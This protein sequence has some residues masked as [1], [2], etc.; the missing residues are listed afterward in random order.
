MPQVSSRN[1]QVH[2]PLRVPR[3]A[4][5][6]RLIFPPLPPC[7]GKAAPA[8][9]PGQILPTPP[10]PP[11]AS[12]RLLV[13]AASNIAPCSRMQEALPPPMRPR[14]RWVPYQQLQH[15]PQIPG[16]ML[17]ARPRSRRRPVA[18]LRPPCSGKRPQSQAA[19][20]PTWARIPLPWGPGRGCMVQRVTTLPM[21][22]SR[23]HR[24]PMYPSSK[25]TSKR[26]VAVHPMQRRC[27]RG[28]M[29][30]P[31]ELHRVI[32]RGRILQS[33][34]TSRMARYTSSRYMR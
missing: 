6:L 19:T 21:T 5:R 10:A 22:R 3:P 23:N 12:Q 18:R 14:L 32:P 1:P 15:S 13:T 9:P 33:T 16:R 8:V 24:M 17:V 11:T 7:S 20:F 30:A 29:E 31:I 27:K 28:Q 2:R 26:G 25:M 4:S 34:S